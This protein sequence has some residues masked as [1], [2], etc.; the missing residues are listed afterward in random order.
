[1]PP[2]VAAEVPLRLDFPPGEAAQVDFGAG[3]LLADVRTGEIF[4]TWFFVMTRCGSRHQYVERVRDPRSA[5]WLACH[6]HALAWFGGV[7]GRII[8]DNAKCAITRACAHDPAVQRAYADGAEGYGF[9]IEACPPRD[10]QK[11]A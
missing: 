6:R 11:K 1:M 2:A 5:T 7:P 9:R 3:P 4:K 8:I 10:P